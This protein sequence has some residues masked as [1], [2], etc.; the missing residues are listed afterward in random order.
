MMRHIIYAQY[1][2]FMF[3]VKTKHE[4]L[5]LR[6]R[7]IKHTGF[8][9]SARNLKKFKNFFPAP[10]S[11]FSFLGFLGL[12]NTCI[13]FQEA[14]V[15]LGRHVI[16]KN[17][18]RCYFSKERK[19]FGRTDIIFLGAEKSWKN[20]YYFSRSSFKFLEEQITDFQENYA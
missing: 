2:L 11:S 13:F 14:P 17:N 19:N 8:P 9:S 16:F 18:N 15:F 10:P 12:G 7:R 5:I 4:T 3:S 1:F 20:R 6:A